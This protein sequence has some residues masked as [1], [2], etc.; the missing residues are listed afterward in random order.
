MQRFLDQA[1]R[2]FYEKKI[3]FCV[4]NEDT[5]HLSH[6][7]RLLSSEDGIATFRDTKKTESEVML[8]SAHLRSTHRDQDTGS[9][10][11]TYASSC[12]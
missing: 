2:H 7:N 4:V 3:H 5:S 6:S 8:G 10:Y 11:Y 9:A 12:A 1:P